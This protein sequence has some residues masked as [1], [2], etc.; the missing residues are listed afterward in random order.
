[1]PHS[2]FNFTF[3][4]FNQVAEKVISKF[5]LINKYECVVEDSVPWLNIYASQL[6][7]PLIALKILEELQSNITDEVL[8][9]SLKGNQLRIVVNGKFHLQSHEHIDFD[10]EYAH[11]FGQTINEFKEEYSL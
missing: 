7:Q 5:K 2:S 1:M 6:I 11:D 4:D 8:F 10:E 9:N 3:N